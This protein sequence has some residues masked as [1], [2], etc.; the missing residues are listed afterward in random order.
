MVDA[1]IATEASEAAVF[2]DL[3]LVCRCTDAG[4]GE[5]VEQ[6]GNNLRDQLA[7][8]AQNFTEAD[9]NPDLWEQNHNVHDLPSL[10]AYARKISAV[11]PNLE[12]RTVLYLSPISIGD[13]AAYTGA[14]S[15]AIRGGLPPNFIL[16]LLAAPEGTLA[17]R[18]GRLEGVTPIEPDLDMPT[19]IQELLAADGEDTPETNFNRHHHA[20]AEAGGA[21]DFKKMHA[22]GDAALAIAENQDGWGASVITIHNTQGA[23]YLNR[24]GHLRQAL[25]AFGKARHAAKIALAT[26][27]PG[28]LQAHIQT[29][30]FEGTT[31]FHLAA[32]DRAA[33]SYLEAADRSEDEAFVVQKLESLRMAS[34]C[35]R[36][37][38]DHRAAW[39]TGLRGID[40]AET[41]AAGQVENS[42]LPY[43][44]EA[45]LGLADELNRDGKAVSTRVTALL[46]PDWRP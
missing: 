44:G 3:F 27:A 7:A 38:G 6:C 45:L 20:M 39:A 36:R 14:L 37:N 35:Q 43:L 33:A 5:W 34:D 24:P 42:T 46:G 1:M 10:I 12:G 19:A 40:V 13:E 16:M 28:A 11:Y 41:M 26:D 30:I 32:Y 31:H 18:L 8:A 2:N 9:V 4:T 22:E 23:L 25:D 21:G 29:L 15:A 17:N